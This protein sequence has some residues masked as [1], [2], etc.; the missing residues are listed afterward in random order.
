MS[1]YVDT[2]D[3]VIVK[4]P[5]NSKR[6]CID[7]RR[8][9]DVTSKDAYPSPHIQA[10]LDKLRGA[11]YLST[12][13]LK[14]GY[15][16]IPLAEKSKPL[17]AFTVPGIGLMQFTVM[18]FGLHSA[19]ATFQRLMDKVLGPELEPNVFVYLDDVIV[20]SKT[21]AEH[22]IHLRNVFIRL[23]AAR[24]KINI[25]KCKF[26]VPN[27]RYLGHIIDRNGTHTDP[28]KV[29]VIKE[30][31]VSRNV[32]Q[33]RQFLGLSSWYR[34]FVDNFARLAEPLI[35][36][37]RK[38]V[39][40]SWRP[41]QGNAFEALK[42]AL[43]STPVLTC[44]DFSR[45]FILQ[46]DVSKIGLGAVLMQESD[47][48]ERVIAYASRTI[49][50]AERNYSA[51]ELECLAVVWGVKHFRGYLEGYKFIVLTDHQSLKWL[52]KLEPPTVD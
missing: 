8:L 10:T 27:L 16:Q 24:L 14:S 40:W 44:P 15:W 21:L 47:K 39:R 34:R 33:A 32:R 29:R 11:Q 22:M 37:T 2:V 35:K 12:I 52:Q 49:N 48:G 6:F 25:A 31:P 5:D 26:C 28:E 4:K 36:L 3:V 13:D 46:T 7:Y 38:K 1:T 9:N 23:R 50:N 42:Q 17:T 41:E 30:W 43:V 20:I 45:P 19:A 18:P 51:T